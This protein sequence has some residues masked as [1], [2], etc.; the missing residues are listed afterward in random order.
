MYSDWGVNLLVA[1][2]TL[3]AVVSCVLVHYEGLSLLSHRL[4]R[5]HEGNPRRKVLF[6]V[7][8]ALGLH[9]FEIWL[10]GL[11]FWRLAMLPGAGAVVGADPLVLL[12]AVYLS[13][14]TYATVGFGDVSPS[15]PL[16][17]V[18]GTEALVG[19][20]MITWSASFMFLEME[21][22]WRR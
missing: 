1:A 9:V 2:A 3:V 15:G 5:R 11:V 21:R 6:G 7:F 19:F 12:D 18:A 8:G 4:L 20:V 22:F 13:A 16:R 17:L 10:F 14:M